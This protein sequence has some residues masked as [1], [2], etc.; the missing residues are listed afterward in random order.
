VKIPNNVRTKINAKLAPFGKEYFTRIP[1]EG[2]FDVLKKE[3]VQV[4]DSDGTLWSGF[5]TG[6]KGRTEFDL[7]IL[8]KT[9]GEYM[10]VENSMLI[11]TWYKMDSGRYEVVCYLS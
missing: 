4:I 11:L 6:A 3:Y 10:P 5:L 7:A 2:I 8:D 1:L 9:T